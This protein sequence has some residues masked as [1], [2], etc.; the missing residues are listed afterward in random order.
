MYLRN[1]PQSPIV[2]VAGLQIIPVRASF[3]H[4]RILFD[5]FAGQYDH[6]P[7]AEATMLHLDD[8][9]VDGLLALRDGV[10]GAY[11]MVLS[12]GDVGT[13]VSL[14]VSAAFRGQGVGRTMMSRALEI[15]A[16]SQFRHV[17]LDVAQDNSVAQG[18]Y[19]ACG[20]EKVGE[21]VALD[22]P[23]A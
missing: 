9:H 19:R 6:P 22:A 5:E 1:A 16:R 8:P 17:F 23:G 10:A 2:E 3:K 21:M 13:I 18:L 11:V 12:S 7:L 14:F 15:C 4:A 20:F